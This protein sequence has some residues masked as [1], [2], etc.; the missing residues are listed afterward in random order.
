MK[1]KDEGK[2]LREARVLVPSKEERNSVTS[3]RGLLFEESETDPIGVSGR[4]A[5]DSRLE[6]EKGKDSVR[7]RKIQQTSQDG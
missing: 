5:A 2:T 7:A 3:G 6:M 1:S 4:P